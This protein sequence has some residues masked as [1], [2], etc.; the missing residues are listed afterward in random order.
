MPKKTKAE[1]AAA[2]AERARKREERE[3]AKKRA[4]AEAAGE[5]VVPDLPKIEE[6][7]KKKP[8]KF[9]VLN[10]CTITGVLS[11][12]EDSRDIQIDHLSLTLFGKELISDTQLHVSVQ[13]RFCLFWILCSG[14]DKKMVGM[15]IGCDKNCIAFGVTIPLEPHLRIPSLTSVVDTDSLAPTDL[16]NPHFLQP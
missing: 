14:I 15:G 10:H 2:A 16:A 13:H 3:R 9:D 12:R 1:K 5:D 7:E 11:S 4:A 6:E 8:E